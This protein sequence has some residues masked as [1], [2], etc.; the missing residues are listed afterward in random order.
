[1][2]DA[3]RI[4]I[5]GGGCAGMHVALRLQRRLRRGE[6]QVTVVD[7]R[8]YLTY[9]PLLAEAAAGSLEPRHVVVPLRQ[10]LPRTRVVTRAV[11]SID[12]ARRVAVLEPC[13]S[14]APD[15]V[16]GTPAQLDYDILVLAP[17]SV[18]RVL[19]VPGL[20]ESGIGFKTIGEAIHLR[21]HV[22][23]ELDAAAALPPGPAQWAA[24][25][26]VFV[27]GGYAGVE[28]LAEL[29]DMARAAARRYPQI[30]PAALRWILVEAADRILPEVGERMGRYTVERL[31]ARGIEV[32]L[33]T[34]LVSA[35]DGHLVFDDGDELDA[36]TLVW[37]AGVAPHPLVKQTDLPLDERGRV[38][39]T[40]FLSVIDTPD[41]W[42]LGDA[43]AVPDLARGAGAL[44]APSAQHAVRQARALADNLI[45]T[46][47][48]R[49]PRPYRHAHAGS[50][51]SLGLYRGVAQ[52][53]GIRTRGPLAWFVH[54]TYH[55]AKLPT[56]NRR[57]RVVADWTLAL[58][59]PREIVSLGA[60]EDARA[61]FK[62]AAAALPTPPQCARDGR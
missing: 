1:M 9:Q 22:L 16:D 50:V 6:A 2:A 37:T 53:Y 14:Q 24:L 40:E 8:S 36:R 59:F 11:A 48:G 49:A 23:A 47:R 39:T 61:D 15:A 26:F 18:S 7:P 51:A 3:P 10:A 21:N 62:A 54:R 19:P 35:H 13:C 28:A 32:R 12:H 34:R 25:T 60:L 27:G 29:E 42:A 31:R 58:L 44:C 56:F 5:V 52:I 43:A 46:L 30:D 20:A 55:L 57:L 17:G 41:A 33:A 45:A 4:L 38:R